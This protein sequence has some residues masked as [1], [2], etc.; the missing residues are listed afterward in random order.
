MSARVTRG[1]ALDAGARLPA[2]VRRRDTCGDDARRH[3]NARA[4][5]VDHRA[6]RV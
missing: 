1:L 5:V 3:K 4:G 2:R 6:R